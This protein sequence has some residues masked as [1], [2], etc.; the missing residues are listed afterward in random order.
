MRQL[1]AKFLQLFVV[2]GLAVLSNAHA[3]PSQLP[4]LGS[5]SSIIMTPAQERRLGKAFLRSVKAREQMHNEPFIREYVETLG[6]TLASSADNPNNKSFNFFILDNPLINAFAGPDGHIGI[7]SGLI[8]TSQTE[9]ELAAVVAHEIAHVTQNHLMRAFHQASELSLPSAA[10]LLAAVV[11]GATVGGDAALATAMGGQAAL[12]QSQINFTRSNEKEADRIGIQTLFDSEFEP[13]AMPVFFE[14]MGR[15]NQ[16][17]SSEIPEFLRTHPVTTNRIADSMARAEQHP[18]RQHQD[19]IGYAL[20][21][22]YLKQQQFANGKESLTYFQTN[23]NEGRYR[24]KQAQQF[25]LFLAQIRLHQ[26]DEAKQTI[27]ELLKENPLQPVYLLYKARLLDKL[28]QRKQAIQLLEDSLLILPGNYPISM[29]LAE[30]YNTNGQHEAA[31]ALLKNQLEYRP[32][33]D[34][35]YKIIARAYGDNKDKLQAHSYQAD[36]LYL[37]GQLE[38][39]IQQLEI[40]LMQPGADFYTSS[41][42]EARLASLKAELEQI[43]ES[44]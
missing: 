32:E 27:D 26:L 33:D 19:S 36:F 12:I 23:L 41:K 21:K 42:L 10:V 3:N 24:N 11:I 29:Q 15:A 6:K 16:T 13:H 44:Q 7:Y 2:A 38:P 18:Y 28:K 40:A 9:S 20:V 37:T 34:Q 17:Y 30:L 39:A 31:I 1:T 43:K 4:E 14:R 5:E 35:I 8:L 25:G 22:A